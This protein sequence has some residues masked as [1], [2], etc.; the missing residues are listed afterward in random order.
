M[1]ACEERASH[2][3]VQ[4]DAEGIAGTVSQDFCD[5]HFTRFML[6]DLIE[7]LE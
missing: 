3:I 2:H 4:V 5:F 6:N 1:V 7:V